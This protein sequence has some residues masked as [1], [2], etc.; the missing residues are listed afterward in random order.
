MNNSA[1]TVD[2]KEFYIKNFG[3]AMPHERKE[4]L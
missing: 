4:T 1:Q 3:R 2:I